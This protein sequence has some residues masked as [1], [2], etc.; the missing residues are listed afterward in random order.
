[1]KKFFCAIA[2]VA[3]ATLSLVSCGEKKANVPAPTKAPSEMN[4][5]ELV[6]A[7]TYYVEEAIAAP[8]VEDLNKLGDAMRTLG[9]YNPVF[10]EI[11]N[12][13]YE[14]TAEQRKTIDEENDK[15]I[16]KYDEMVSKLEAGEGHDMD[17]LKAV[18]SYGS[19]FLFNSAQLDKFKPISDRCNEVI[20]KRL[21]M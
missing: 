10:N 19:M 3:L 20:K 14:L 7:W 13:R 6:Q 4:A 12:G 15:A 17:R 5:D 1:M 8:D 11:S 9:E 16:A 18:I 21:G 2:L